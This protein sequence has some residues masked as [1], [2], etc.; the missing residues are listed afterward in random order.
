MDHSGLLVGSCVFL[1]FS[2]DSMF[3]LHWV[4]L[5]QVRFYHN[6]GMDPG[7]L[8]VGSC[9]FLRFQLDSMFAFQWA[10][11]GQVRFYFSFGVG[12]SWAP[13]FFLRFQLD[14]IIFSLRDRFGTL[15]GQDLQFRR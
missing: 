10:L 6:F 7:G 4:P 5:G 12:S 1:G 3:P 14:T 2:L 13:V 11:L 9:V 15:F 8:L